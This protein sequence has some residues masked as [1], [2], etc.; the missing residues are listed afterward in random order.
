MDLTV[1]EL[2]GIVEG[3]VV[4]GDP[5]AR[6][7]G[8]ASLEAATGDQV[9]FFGNSK[10]AP[11]LATTRAGAVL[12]PGS[13]DVMAPEATA[14]L[15]VENPM[16]AFDLIVRRFGVK[17][18]PFEAGIH[19]TAFVGK[20]CDV[21]SE[22]VSI[23]PNASILDG[24]TIGEGTRIGAGSVICSGAKIGKNCEVGPN[25]TIREGCILGDN[26][27][28][29]PGVV[30]G[31]DGFGFE[32]KDGRH[33]KIEQLGIVRI[34]DNVE[35]GAGTTIDRAR[36]GETVIGEGTKIDNLVQI[37]HNCI[38]GK[39]CIIVAQTGISGSA[40]VGDYSVIAAQSGIAGHLEIAPQTT[41]GGRSGVI[42]SITEP[43]GTYFGYPAKPIKEDR[44]INMHLKKL[45]GLIRK[46]K[47]LEQRLE[48]WDSK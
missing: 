7:R 15:A 48:D 38:I 44:R 3:T 34:E 43:G 26:V 37:A 45:G 41:L 27:I 2:A 16:V 6:L 12:I 29:H 32:F 23:L 10:Y 20:D 19:E 40:R 47:E 1:E 5:G 42:A 13:E 14:L 31:G 22:R 28:V 39:H 18:P 17:P 8:F 35:I 25:V 46:V 9:S 33:Q 24:V 30:I 11:Q 21:D 4:R 36:F